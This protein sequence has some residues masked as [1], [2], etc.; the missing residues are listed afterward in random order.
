[1]NPQDATFWQNTGLIAGTILLIAIGLVVI[2]VMRRVA[3]GGLDT[4]DDLLSPL[5]QAYRAGQMDSAEFQRIQE[6]VDRQRTGQNLDPPP[7][8]PS[9]P[10]STETA[11]PDHPG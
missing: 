11:T 5:Q 4:E 9:P 1:M 8:R 7:Q 6:S 3:K 10:E 2:N